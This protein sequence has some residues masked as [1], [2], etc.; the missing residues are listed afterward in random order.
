MRGLNPAMAQ[1]LA[2]NIKALRD[3]MGLTQEQFADALDTS[4]GSV[5]RWEGGS[6]PKL[7]KLE[8]L[9]E[10]AGR[11]ITEFSSSIW[12]GPVPKSPAPQAA[13]FTQPGIFMP[14]MLPSESALTEMFHALLPIAGVDDAQGAIAR[15][16]AQLLPD[17]LAQTVF[18]PTSAAVDQLASRSDKEVH[19]TSSVDYR[20]PKR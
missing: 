12:A 1:I 9:A 18:R 17:A 2:T 8:K 19:S 6:Q 7:E 11:S 5:A 3:S 4:Q 14:V 13:L 16:L 15:M 10:M 20:A